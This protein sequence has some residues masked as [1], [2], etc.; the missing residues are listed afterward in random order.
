MTV[1]LFRLHSRVYGCSYTR[2]T[3]GAF[4]AF[5]CDKSTDFSALHKLSLFHPEVKKIFV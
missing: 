5:T 2:N 1:I 3:V 4:I